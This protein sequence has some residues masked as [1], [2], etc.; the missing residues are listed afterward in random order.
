MAQHSRPRCDRAGSR[1]LERGGFQR[2]VRAHRA[3]F[4]AVGDLVMGRGPFARPRPPCKVR[5]KAWQFE[6]ARVVATISRAPM[7]PISSFLEAAPTSSMRGTGRTSFL[8]VAAPI[9]SMRARATTSCSR[10][11]VPTRSTAGMATM[12]SSAATDATR[13]MVARAMTTSMVAMVPTRSMVAR[14]M[15][16]FWAD[17][18]ATSYAAAR[19][20]TSWMV[21]VAPTA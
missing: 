9:R 11:T 4:V 13:S 5:G 6:L 16:S 12:P 17:A 3:V 19:A 1:R 8:P 2:A 21:A 7:P 18:A 10:A 15:T 20:M 14:A